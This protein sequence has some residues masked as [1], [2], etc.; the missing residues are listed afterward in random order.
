LMMKFKAA[1]VADVKK[2]FNA[3]NGYASQIDT[4]TSM[5]A[6][7]AEN[8]AAKSNTYSNTGAYTNTYNT[9]TMYSEGI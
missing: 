7:Y 5:I 1:D 6:Y 3:E 4:Q 8:E 9:G 2:V